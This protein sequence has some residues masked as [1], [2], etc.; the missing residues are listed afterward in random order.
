MAKKQF[1]TTHV[2]IDVCAS[3]MLR[4]NTVLQCK[5]SSWFVC[6]ASRH[7]V[8]DP[9]MSLINKAEYVICDVQQLPEMLQT[10]GIQ[11]QDRTR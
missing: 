5:W 3:S 11:S 8:Q 2:Y 1:A 10:F 4:S 7:P 9:V 6:Q